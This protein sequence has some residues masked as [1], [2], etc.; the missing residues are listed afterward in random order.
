M[1]SIWVMVVC[2][3]LVVFVNDIKCNQ[4][5]KQLIALQTD[6]A[7]HG[8]QIRANNKDINFLTEGFFDEYELTKE[9]VHKRMH[10]LVENEY[11]I[12][13]DKRICEVKGSLCSVWW[14]L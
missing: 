8:Q 4:L 3:W 13:R 7:T 14:I 11:V 5:R 1:K 9:Q 12:R 6:N 2:L 10:D